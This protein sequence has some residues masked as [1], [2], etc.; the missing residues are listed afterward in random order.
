[1]TPANRKVQ[2]NARNFAALYWLRKNYAPRPLLLH[3]RV[4]VLRHCDA[5]VTNFTAAEFPVFIVGAKRTPFGRYGGALKELQPADMFAAVA[6]DVLKAANV[7][8]EIVDTVNVGIVNAVVCG[9]CLSLLLGHISRW[10]RREIA[11]SA[12]SLARSA[13]AE[14]DNESCYFM[15][16]A[17][18]GALAPRHGALK[19]GVPRERPALGV[20]RLC[21]SGFQAV[22]N[23]AQD[24]ISGA[25]NISLT[26]GTENMSAVPY[27]VRN[28]RF[29]TALGSS[30]EFEDALTKGSLDTYCNFT[31]P[32]TAENLA[33]KYKLTREEVDTFA[34]ESQQKWKAAHDSGHFEAELTPLTVRV[35][36]QEVTVQ[37]DEHP[38]PDTTREALAQLP[39]LFR[40]G[41]VVTAGNSSGVNDGAGAVIVASEE[42][43]KQHGLKPLA[44]LLGW[45]YV[46]VDPSIMGIGPVPAIQGLLSATGTKLQDV[47]LIELFE[48]PRAVPIEPYNPALSQKS[49]NQWH[50]LDNFL[51]VGYFP[52]FVHQHYKI[53][54]Q[55]CRRY[56]INEAFAAQTLACVKELGLDPSKLNV[57]G[58]AVAIGHPLAASGAR[59]TAHL[60]H[61]LRRRGLKKAIGSACIGGG[62]GIALLVET[63]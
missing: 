15:S 30:I 8:P 62:Q 56:I 36:K 32:Q 51:S 13:Q 5:F 43:V 54:W 59:I 48:R 17:S 21:G 37:R 19:A 45:S 23:G 14:R 26:G 60:V 44:R 42:A 39:V 57:N 31:M 16:G 25:A 58:G 49:V 2:Y 9:L 12:L 53:L 4:P 41:G 3:R 10:S 20:N 46:G 47:D 11:R 38:R 28:V 35:R 61:E 27:L 55:H 50:G 29:G 40:K 22:I 33:E 7:A 34:Y 6:T 24:I 63:V 52:D 1:M 18:D